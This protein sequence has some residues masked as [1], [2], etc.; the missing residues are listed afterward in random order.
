MITA[1]E[2]TAIGKVIKTHGIHGEMNVEL[3][4]GERVSPDD[5]RCVVFDIDGIFVPFFPLG[6]RD[7]GN[8]RSLLSLEDID[9]ETKASTFVGK[10]I[11]ALTD[12][13]PESVDDGYLTLDDL[14]G[15]R[16]Q[17][18]DSNMVGVITGIDDST[19]NVL[20]IVE[21][22]D[23]TEIQVPAAEELIT[24]V[25]PEDKLLTMNLPEGLF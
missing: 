12:E 3:Y 19:I 7:R 5:L 20:F 6:S 11:Y 10:E 14:V 25:D 18:I 16:I 23:E 4:D 13:L 15:Y 8:G 17:D 1:D 22:P 9:S 24:G 2:L 21:R